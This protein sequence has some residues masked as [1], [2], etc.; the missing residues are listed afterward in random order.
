MV[1]G[2]RPKLSHA[3]APMRSVPISAPDGRRCSARPTA[4]DELL[5]DPSILDDEFDE[6]G[7]EVPMLLRIVNQP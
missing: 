4:G 1:H 7:C 6:F 5:N 2:N 3:R